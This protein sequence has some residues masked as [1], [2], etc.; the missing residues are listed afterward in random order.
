M[1]N[2]PIL[3]C[4][5]QLD[6]SRTVKAWNAEIR[7]NSGRHSVDQHA[8]GNADTENCAHDLSKGSRHC[9]EKQTGG[10]P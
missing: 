8:N 7:P 9:V 1:Q 5:E 2:D 4:A 10:E 6:P 3:L